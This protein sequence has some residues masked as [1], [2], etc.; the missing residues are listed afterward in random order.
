[1]I[2]NSYDSAVAFLGNKSSRNVP[3]KRATKIMRMAD[4]SIA[5]YYHITPVVTWYPDGRTILR[6][7]GNHTVTTKRRINQAT[8]V[9]VWQRSFEWWV[10]V[11]PQS[12]PE[13]FAEGM[14]V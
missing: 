6:T 5:M 11:T 12:N 7:G 10:N 1:M 3:G 9:R 8:N 2:P 4:D 13:P 14:V